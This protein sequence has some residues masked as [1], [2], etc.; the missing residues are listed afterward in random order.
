MPHPHYAR[1]VLG[2]IEMHKK[3]IILFL[4]FL[5]VSCESKL[6]EESNEQA[7][8]IIYHGGDGIPDN[9]QERGHDKYTTFK[10]DKE[11]NNIR[12]FPNLLS[13]ENDTIIIYEPKKD[14]S[15]TSVN[16]ISTGALPEKEYTELISVQTSNHFEA[17]LLR[18][19]LQLKFF[20]RMK[21]REEGVRVRVINNQFTVS[22]YVVDDG[23]TIYTPYNLIPQPYTESERFVHWWWVPQEMDLYLFLNQISYEV[24]DTIFGELNYVGS[25]R[26][27]TIYAKGG[28]MGV[29]R[30]G[31]QLTLT[32]PKKH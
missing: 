30:E 4:M 8:P 20:E 21:F 32:T 24:G 7:Q 19:T 10:V 31:K 16:I 15:L 1:A 14:S 28:F 27:S 2:S 6:S 13:L 9:L 29:V 26:N 17:F 12:L 11:Y 25:F 18:D 5:T 3:L 23:N 22:P